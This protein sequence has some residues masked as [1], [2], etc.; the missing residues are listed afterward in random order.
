MFQ[1]G[2]RQRGTAQ[3]GVEYDSGRVDGR[4]ERLG[5]PALDPLPDFGSPILGDP[6]AEVSRP[7][8]GLARRIGD[9]VARGISQ[10]RLEGRISKQAIH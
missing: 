5:R 4:A 10:E 3:V 2:C 9:Q 1:R 6:G 8:Q 7:I